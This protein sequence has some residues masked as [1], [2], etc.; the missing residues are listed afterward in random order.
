MPTNLLLSPG[1]RVLYKG[2]EYDV[3]VRDMDAQRLSRHMLPKVE[4]DMSKYLVSPMP[5]V[6]ISVAVEPGQEVSEGQ[7]LAIVEAMKMQNV[8]RAEKAGVVKAVPTTA[9]DVSFGD[10][11]IAD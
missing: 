10:Q 9:G 7:E 2:G 5:G 4:V 6:L 8:L 3:T 1:Y 11:P